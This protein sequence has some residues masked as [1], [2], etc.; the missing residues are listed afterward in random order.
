MN[1]LWSLP[2]LSDKFNFVPTLHSDFN[3]IKTKQN[4]EKAL[5]HLEE[6][7]VY[8]KKRLHSGDPSA[9]VRLEY[10]NK[11][12]NLILMKNKIDDFLL[13]V[14]QNIGFDI[15]AANRIEPEAFSSWLNDIL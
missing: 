2:P 4:R 13:A 3:L 9:L 14:V 6:R 1:R 7:K 12:Y 15:M 8:W 10:V 5:N 11:A